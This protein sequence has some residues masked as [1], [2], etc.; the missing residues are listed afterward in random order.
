MYISEIQHVT[1]LD[2]GD[3][4]RSYCLEVESRMDILVRHISYTHNLLRSRGSQFLRCQSG[5]TAVEY[6]LI[7]S[8]VS[9]SLIAGATTIG[10]TL[11]DYFQILS[12]S[13]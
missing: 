8:L 6:G 7:V 4:G 11:K 5:A 13:F 9:F 1:A 2:P 10:D 3:D 12:G